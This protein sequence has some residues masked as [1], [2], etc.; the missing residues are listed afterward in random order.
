LVTFRA[1]LASE[2]SGTL[3]TITVASDYFAKEALAWVKKHPDD[4][5]DADVLGFAMRV[6][7]NG[8]RSDATDELNHQ[9]F[10][11]LHRL[12]PKSEWAKRYTPGSETVR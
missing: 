10:D 12:F 8:C 7:R 1:P 5:H 2:F 3:E 4:P 6:V 9:L 11:I